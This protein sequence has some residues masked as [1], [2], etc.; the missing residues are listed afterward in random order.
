LRLLISGLLRFDSG[1]TTTGLGLLSRFKEVGITIRPLKPVAGHNSWYSFST[2]LR[3]IEMGIL[4]GN[5]ALKY[6][7]ESGVDVREINPFAVMLGVPDP[8]LFM[9]S[10]RTYLRYMEEGMPI[11]LRLEDCSSRKGVHLVT[12]SVQYLPSGLRK[13]VEELSLKVEA[14][15]VEEREAR[16]LVERSWLLAD[17]CVKMWKGDLLIESY[18]DAAV[19]TPSSLDVEIVLIVAPGRVF[20]YDGVRFKE[21][22]TTLGSPWNVSSYDVFRLIR[23]LESMPLD[24]ISPN[25]LNRVADKIIKMS[26]G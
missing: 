12:R 1:K 2:L 18:N 7:D 23:P 22:V 15:E 17:G 3:S 21:A 5:D 19:P 24:P 25:S 8:A 14:I 20:M 6:H 16:E 13:Y 4:A 26:G 11:M 9:D 10:T